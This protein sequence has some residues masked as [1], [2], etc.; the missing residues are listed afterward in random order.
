MKATLDQEKVEKTDK[1]EVDDAETGEESIPVNGEP[2]E[3]VV[4]D[5][6]VQ[7][8]ASK[9]DF[10]TPAVLE[11]DSQPFIW[12]EDAPVAENYSK[13]GTRLAEAGDL[14]R[15]SA[16]A[17]GLLLAS[18]CPMVPPLPITKALDLSP[19]I[20]DRVRVQVVK[21]G[22]PKSG[23][24][25]N[26]HCNIMLASEVFLQRF[27]A[28]DT[29][30]QVPLYLR[31]FS[32]TVPGYNSGERGQ[33]IFFAGQAAAIESSM[34]VINQ[35]LDTMAFAANAD[36]TNTLAAALT[37]LLRNHFLGAKPFISVTANKSHAGK[38]TIVLFVSGSNRLTSISY[39]STD[40]ALERSF[41]GAVKHSPET[42]V[43]NIENARLDR[44]GGFI[45][46]GFLER[47]ITDP[48]PTLFSTGSGGPTRRRNDIVVAITTNFGTLS[49]DLL[50]RSLPI[51]LTP[52]G[53]IEDR[54]PIIGNPKQDFLPNN[55]QRIEA[56]MH[57]MVS[58]WKE[59]GQPLDKKVKHP[60]TEWAQTI[61]G[62]LKANGYDEFLANYSTRKAV[63][64]PL[65]KGL[66]L[67]GAARP[68]HWIRSGNWAEIA[69]KL[70]L[71]KVLIPEADR[72]SEKGRERGIGVVMSAHQDETFHAE[73]EDECLVVRLRRARRRFE[74]G[75]ISTRYQFT[76]IDREELPADDESSD[77]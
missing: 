15:S 67:L 54:K 66:G 7:T 48:E 4:V 50:N 43:M 52:V 59:A 65:R 70:G 17:G 37:V 35:F 29:V 74:Q 11:P 64:D 19:I 56:E 1:Q 62:I 23:R 68:D 9:S 31:D 16:Y 77:D 30:T 27:P 20:A 8:V 69:A 58:R 3:E 32:L 49:T 76:V 44:K 73:T 12:S 39:Q 25:A 63:D 60:F 24:I 34:E 45:A 36:R 26:A 6:G 55:R 38:D 22:K 51:H 71:V 57:G 2:S 10:P 72:D 18:K 47:F 28:I 14:Y 41:V 42:A 75:K 21:D 46:S 53:N 13:L 61:G 33:R 40:W 5:A